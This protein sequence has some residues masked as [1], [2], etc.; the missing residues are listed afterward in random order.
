MILYKN[1][2]L[3][4]YLELVLLLI[5]FCC[6]V[7]IAY[8]GLVMGRIVLCLAKPKSSS[9][10]N[11]L[12]QAQLRVLYGPRSI[13][14]CTNPQDTRPAPFVL[15]GPIRVSIS[16]SMCLPIHIEF[17]LTLLC[18]FCAYSCLFYTFCA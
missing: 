16:A 5:L 10:K 17:G 15:D 7:C 4:L 12:A 6:I 11:T 9:R 1:F 18:L 3:K 13:N 14:P 2:Q 8:T